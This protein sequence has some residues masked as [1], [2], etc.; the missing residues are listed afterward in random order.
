MDAEPGFTLEETVAFDLGVAAGEERGWNA[1]NPFDSSTQYD[2]WDAWET[3][4]SVGRMT[5]TG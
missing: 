2:E 3:G 5:A 1:K 4:V